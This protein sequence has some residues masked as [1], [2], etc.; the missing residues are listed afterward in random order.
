VSN[1]ANVKAY[2]MYDPQPFASHVLRIHFDEFHFNVIL[3]SPLSP[4]K[5]VP[6]L[7][8]ACATCVL[9]LTNSK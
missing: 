3:P 6:S 2:H 4:Q 8:V 1:D 7:R 9:T 5:C